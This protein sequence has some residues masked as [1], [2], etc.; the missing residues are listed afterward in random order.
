MPSTK[1]FRDR[2]LGRLLPVGPVEARSMFGGFGL[3]LDGV[4]F[5]LIAF[6]RLYFKIDDANRQDFIE[7]G[8]QA[9]SYQGKTRRIEMSYYEL[10]GAVL[11]DPAELID[12]AGRACDAARRAKAKRRPRRKRE[13]S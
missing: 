4:M 7:A 9:F 12:W 5:A 11:D 10:P 2:M 13:K 6:D 8:T 3:Y 1:A